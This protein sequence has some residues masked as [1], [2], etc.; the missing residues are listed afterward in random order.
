MQ[1]D[2]TQ[3][4]LF[5]FQYSR[6]FQSQP[7]PNNLILRPSLSTESL[8]NMATQIATT[9]RQSIGSCPVAGSRALVS[10]GRAEIIYEAYGESCVVQSFDAFLYFDSLSRSLS[11]PARP[12]DRHFLTLLGHNKFLRM[13]SVPK[14]SVIKSAVTPW[15]GFRSF[16]GA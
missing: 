11:Y 9:Y 3:L 16:D 8:I 5:L 7:P 14:P 6:F 4:L 15:V 12:Y 13:S 1:E 2:S 10:I